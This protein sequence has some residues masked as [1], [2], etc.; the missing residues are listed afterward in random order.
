[1]DSYRRH[2]PCG[3]SETMRISLPFD[4]HTLECREVHC[5]SPLNGGNYICKEVSPLRGCVGELTGDI[6]CTSN[7]GNLAMEFMDDFFFSFVIGHVATK[8]I[9]DDRPYFIGSR[10][11]VQFN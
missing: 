5:K 4:Q 11:D 1:M 9:G 6:T 7:L 3:D 10:D 2:W 8:M